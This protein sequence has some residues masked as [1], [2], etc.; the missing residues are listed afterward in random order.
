MDKVK[1]LFKIFSNKI[2]GSFILNS[3]KEKSTKFTEN[4]FE[5][6]KMLIWENKLSTTE[7][8][9]KNRMQHDAC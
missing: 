8:T 9:K 6:K 7:S 1:Y 5:N 4:L 3:M 2:N